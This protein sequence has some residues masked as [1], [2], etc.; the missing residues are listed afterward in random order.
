MNQNAR[1]PYASFETL[2]LQASPEAALTHEIGLQ[3]KELLPLASLDDLEK[4]VDGGRLTIGGEHLDVSSLRPYVPEQLF[5]VTDEGDLAVKL[6]AAVHTALREAGTP[7]RGNAL[8]ADP[9]R[10]ELARTAARIAGAE[11]SAGYFG[12]GTILGG[13]SAQVTE[14]GGFSDWLVTLRLGDCVTGA[15]LPWSWITDGINTYLFGWDAQFH[16]VVPGG[17]EGYGVRIMREGYLNLYV[18]LV[19]STME[20]TTQDLCLTPATG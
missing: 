11:S 8:R 15:P 13:E 14:E 16:A 10:T 5:P 3:L 17:W 20:G 2:L 6:T 19:R 1:D 4:K 12:D 18:V 7:G 9:V